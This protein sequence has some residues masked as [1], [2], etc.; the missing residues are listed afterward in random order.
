LFGAEFTQV[1][2]QQAGREL[3]PSHYAIRVQTKEVD[4][5]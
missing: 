4:S 2:A 1:Y 5:R 3:E